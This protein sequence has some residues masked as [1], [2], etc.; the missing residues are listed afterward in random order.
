V[1]IGCFVAFP[2][3]LIYRIGALGFV[4][5]VAIAGIGGLAKHSLGRLARLP[6]VF[7]YFY[8]VNLAAFL[9]IVMAMSGRVEV[10]WTPERR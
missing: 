8:M 2:A 3:G 7:F 9:G 1:A 6:Q 5:S 4:A 10:I